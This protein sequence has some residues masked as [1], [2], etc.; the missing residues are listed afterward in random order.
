M[1]V[2]KLEE[3]LEK[4]RIDEKELKNKYLSKKSEEELLKA[5]ERIEYE[6]TLLKEKVEKLSAQQ[7]ETT[8][9]LGELKTA[10]SKEIFKKYLGYCDFIEK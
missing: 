2:M 5:L 6:N 8:E 4:T 10:K 1:K 3:K 7:K 9:F